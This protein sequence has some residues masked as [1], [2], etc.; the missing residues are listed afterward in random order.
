MGIKSHSIE[1]SLQ[2]LE[3]CAPKEFIDI[4]SKKIHQLDTLQRPIKTNRNF[5]YQWAQD[6]M[7]NP[8]KFVI[9]PKFIS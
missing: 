2:S 8:H 3:L 4:L 6:L 1:S 5:S 7:S 9:Q